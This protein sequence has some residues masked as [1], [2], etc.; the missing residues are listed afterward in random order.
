MS[1]KPPQKVRLELSAQAA[2]YA[3]RDAPREARLM[4]ARGALPLQPVELAT[5]LFAL[6]HDP[7][8]EVKSKARDSL[9]S[10]PPHVV[11]TVVEQPA[12]APLLDHLARSAPEDEERLEKI[13]L[14]AA[15][16]DAT[17]AFLAGRPFK[18]IVDIVSNNQK[19][20]LRYPPIVDALGDNPLT[21][22]AVIDRIL[23]FLGVDSRDEEEE[24]DDDWLDVEEDVGDEE[25]QAAL[26]AILGDSFASL[27]Q[28]GDGEIDPDELEQ[29][30]S[31]YSVIQNLSVF[32][33]IKLA[34]MGNK[35][36]RSLLVRDRNKIVAMAAVTSPKI[37]D[38]EM[39]AIAQSRNVCDDVIR[40]IARNRDVTR[41]YQV[42]HALAT[43]PKTPQ[44]TAMQFVNYLQDRDLRQ[45]MKSK[46]VPTVV[47][48]HARRILTR[49]G[50]L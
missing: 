33:K 24:Q 28:D 41:N 48:T 2:K 4:A 12:P 1:E 32:Q 9:E 44:A 36:A 21:G 31:L 7:D 29:G 22:R 17:V 37:S 10:L 49:K 19:R 14:N 34:R 15:T 27:T 11:G 39:I 25:A 26:Q 40:V 50:K 20:L 38:T 23:S 13:A 18:K 45:L 3:R 16:G 43:N 8:A 30:G 47:A 5:V 46:D 6:M 35:E 42:K